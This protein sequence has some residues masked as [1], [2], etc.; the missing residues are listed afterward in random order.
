MGTRW[1]SGQVCRM[2]VCTKYFRDG[3][4]RMKLCLNIQLVLKSS[5]FTIIIKNSSAEQTDC[6]LRADC[7]KASLINYIIIIWLKF[8]N[9][10]PSVTPKVPLY[11]KNLPRPN[12]SNH[13][14][15]PP[16]PSCALQFMDSPK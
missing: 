13:R 12:A 5:L 6:E 8:Y 4:L 3:A 2:A 16:F 9:S 11:L 15:P 10:S 7:T 1:C 14:P